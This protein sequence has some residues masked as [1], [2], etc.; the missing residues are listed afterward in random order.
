AI[1][2]NELNRGG[3]GCRCMTMPIQRGE[4]KI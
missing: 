4:I 3:G 1:S 2:G